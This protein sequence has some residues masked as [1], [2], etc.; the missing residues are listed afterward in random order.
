M[1]KQFH[2]VSRL[3]NLDEKLNN[4]NLSKHLNKLAE[5]FGELAQSVNKVIGI[6]R[7]KP[8]ETSDDIKDNIGEEIA[9]CTQILFVIAHLNGIDYRTIIDKFNQKNGEYETDIMHRS[10]Q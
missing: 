10:N 4:N 5:E 1:E 3:A 7:I 6:K 2:D 9:D 8:H